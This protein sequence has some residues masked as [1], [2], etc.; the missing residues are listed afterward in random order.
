MV[1]YLQAKQ[2]EGKSRRKLLETMAAV[3][4]RL[5]SPQRPEVKS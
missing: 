2:D 3:R 5:N 4:R 1:A